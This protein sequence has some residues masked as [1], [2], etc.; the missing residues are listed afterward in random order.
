M[1]KFLLF[2]TF[3]C[4]AAFYACDDDPYANIR[5]YVSSEV[6]Y[7]EKFDTISAAIGFERVEIYLTSGG[8]SDS[9]KYNPDKAK[10]TIVE[11]DGET[12]EF[13]GMVSW[14]NVTGLDK[15]KLYR[16]KVYTIDDEGNKSVPQEISKI[17]FTK[18]DRDAISVSD[19]RSILSPWGIS[20]SWPGGLS[21]SAWN[22][23][24]CEYNF[25][26]RNND[27]IEGELIP[28]G[29]TP[30]IDAT[31]LEP[32]STVK[33]AF[34][35]KV[36]P[37][38]DDVQ[39]LDTV[40]FAQELEVTM[41]TTEEYGQSVKSREIESW[42][43]SGTVA[44]IK[45]KTVSDYTMVNTKV[46]YKDYSSGSPVQKTI[47]VE[48]T[49]TQLQLPGLIFERVEI[50]SDYEPVGGEGAI[51]TAKT[52]SIL[53]DF[54]DPGVMEFNK[55]A[56]TV[57]PMSVTKLIYYIHCDNFMDVLFFPNLTELDFT[58]GGANLPRSTCTGNNV[59][60]DVGNCPWNFG[61]VRRDLNPDLASFLSLKGIT[62]LK[63]LLASG[64]ITKVKYH[65]GTLKIDND[66]GAVANKEIDTSPAEVLFTDKIFAQG[67]LVSTDWLCENAYM[68]TDVPAGAG[69]YT[70]M[71]KI[72]PKGKSASFCFVYPQEYKFN[73]E[74]YRY[75]KM[76]VRPPAKSVFDNASNVA[77]AAKFKRLW[78][79][80]RKATLW[81]HSPMPKWGSVSDGD[82]NG[83]QSNGDKAFS[84]SELGTWVD[85]SYDLYRIIKATDS[86]PWY[87]CLVI[88]IGCEP[89]VL[90]GFDAPYYFADIRWSKTP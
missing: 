70:H 29:S 48:N 38:V 14:V 18:E 73:L 25:T 16:F 27:P 61:F 58:G 68:P 55:I 81:G 90:P 28:D 84:D 78:F 60:N 40:K 46:V 56:R 13:D 79:R 5:K 50:T 32:G 6:I 23:A 76:K 65:A 19:P 39:I 1:K 88:N 80:S 75:L 74:E 10:K 7:P 24:G 89:G 52:S 53:P 87:N 11:Y 17:P 85:V 26:D 82:I 8:R 51:I 43:Y 69:S 2:L 63:N 44:T 9:I 33:I 67:L 30:R 47:T 4:F 59:S 15:A 31:N 22:F 12:Q 35:V 64:K 45:W 71:W 62:V 86:A 36:V 34:E 66:L 54:A 72:T 41:P 77:N 49:D 83:D 20:L 57:D 37:I 21:T 42:D 3:V